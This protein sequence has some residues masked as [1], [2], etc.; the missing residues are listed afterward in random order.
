MG[1]IIRQDAVDLDTHCKFR[2]QIK[3]SRPRYFVAGV[4]GADLAGGAWN[5]FIELRSVL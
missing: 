1:N 3:A 2:N 5:N 4:A